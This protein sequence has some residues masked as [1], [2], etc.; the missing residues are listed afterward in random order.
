MRPSK[1]LL[2]ALLL[3]VAALPVCAKKERKQESS[4]PSATQSASDPN[5]VLAYI[6]DKPVTRAEVDQKAANRLADIRQK[7]FDIRKATLD[8]MVQEQLSQKEAAARGISVDDLLKAEIEQKVTAPTKEEVN[9]FYEENKARM[10]GRTLEQV[11][12]DIEN[13]LK[14]QRSQERRRDFYKELMK[15]EK[16]TILLDPPRVTVNLQAD[17]P[18]RGPKEAPVTIV[19]FSDFQCPFCKRAHGL[20]EE[21]VKAYPD[22]VRL[23]YLDYPLPMHPQAFPAAEAAHCAGA[24][25]KY[26]EYHNSLMTVEGSLQDDDLKK[27]AS[28]LG[29]NAETFAKCLEGTE[30]EPAIKATFEQGSSLGVTGTP[31]FFINGRM[32]VGARSIE[33]IKGMVDEEIERA[34]R[35]AGKT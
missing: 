31:T 13:Y 16:V 22:K 21:V 3:V 18:A 32:I 33:E 2:A 1:T 30:F 17:A 11:S 26:W 5:E 23:V 9:K 29:L 7:E 12:G 15:K 27:R 19:E 14:Q 25:G 28:D 34:G 6:G 10:S 4:T 24:Q 35:K 20:V 8:G